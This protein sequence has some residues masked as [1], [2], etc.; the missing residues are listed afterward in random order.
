MALLAFAGCAGTGATENVDASIPFVSTLE[1]LIGKWAFDG[2]LALIVERDGDVL[3]IRNPPNA[4]W[5]FEISEIS[6]DGTSVTFTQRH[7]LSDGAAH[8]FNDVPCK[9]TI[10]P[11]LDDSESLNY[12]FTSAQLPDGDT[13]VLSRLK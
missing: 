3:F 1:P 2:E 9:C 6:T 4:T 11:V 8:P 12:K 10:S 5:R 13:D 7:Y